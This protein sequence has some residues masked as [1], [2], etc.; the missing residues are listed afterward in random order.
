MSGG[1]RQRTAI[2]RAL[3]TNPACV[4]ADEPTGNLDETTASSIIELM[5]NLNKQQNSAMIIVTHDTSLAN[6][7]N[8]IYELS[9]HQLMLKKT[10]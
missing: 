10:N 5:L 3:V 8:K 2:A 7:M 6:R 1:E 9:G 4:L